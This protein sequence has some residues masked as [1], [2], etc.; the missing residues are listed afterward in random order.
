M[1]IFLIERSKRVPGYRPRKWKIRSVA[2]AAWS[3]LPGRPPAAVSSNGKQSSLQELETMDPGR[4]DTKVRENNV[5]YAID[6]LRWP[7]GIVVPDGSLANR[8]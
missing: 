2:I 6:R 7:I 4:T 8:Y 1:R 5:A 3:S